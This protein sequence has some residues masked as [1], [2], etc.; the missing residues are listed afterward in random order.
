MYY[1]LRHGF[2]KPNKENLIDYQLGWSS[3]EKALYIKDPE[4]E[5]V[6]QPVINDKVIQDFIEPYIAQIDSAAKVYFKDSMVDTSKIL[7]NTYERNVVYTISYNYEGDDIPDDELGKN[8][9]SIQSK[10]EAIAKFIED[11]QDDI[12]AEGAKVVVTDNVLQNVYF[13]II[14]RDEDD[15][16][17]GKYLTTLET[18]LPNMKITYDS[19]TNTIYFS[20]ADKV[21]NS[22]SLSNMKL[23]CG[24]WD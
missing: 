9:Y 14:I 8:Y 23:D 24:S 6:I 11:W 12:D 18:S 20:I 10:D 7:R 3:E 16:L 13:Y 1:I 5:N 4:K 17:F 22:V 15:K 19:A 21:I 2:K